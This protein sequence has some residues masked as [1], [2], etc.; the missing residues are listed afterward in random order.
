MYV[1]GVGSFGFGLSGEVRAVPD[2][3]AERACVEDTFRRT[4]TPMALQASGREA[5]HASAVLMPEGVV[6]LC[7]VSE[8]GKSTLAFALGQRG[9]PLWADDAVVLEMAGSGAVAQPLDFCIKLRPASSA[10]F[11]PGDAPAAASPR[12]EPLAAI[13]VLARSDAPESAAVDV[14]RLPAHRAFT[15][16]LTHAYCFT[17]DD[18]AARRR[19]LE[20]YMALTA[21]VPVLEVRFRPGLEHVPAI[22]DAIRAAVHSSREAA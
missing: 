13:I 3:G 14:Q 4:I 9:F 15:A 2:P 6:A 1:P 20:H 16:V 18:A 19:M 21:A 8:T 22:L 7:A 17:L 11:G 10:Y 12:P 5:L